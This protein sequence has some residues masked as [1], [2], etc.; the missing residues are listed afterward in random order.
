MATATSLSEQ[1]LNLKED[2]GWSWSEMANQVEGALNVKGPSGS[3][4]F[5]YAK[6]QANPSDLVEQTV[7]KAIQS[8]RE[9]QLADAEA[10]GTA[11]A[12][13]SAEESTHVSE[14]EVS[15]LAAAEP[16]EAV[17]TTDR[18]DIAKIT[19][20][21]EELVEAPVD[22]VEDDVVAE[23]PEHLTIRWA[24]MS[25]ATPFGAGIAPVLDEVI[26]EIEEAQIVYPT[27]SEQA[28]HGAGIPIDEILNSDVD[29]EIESLAPQSIEWAVLETEI[30]FAYGIS[31][32][33]VVT[34]VQTA[35][36]AAPAEDVVVT[37]EVAEVDVA[38][39]D[40]ELET[41][42]SFDIDEDTLIE[43]YEML[44]VEEAQTA[45]E[46]DVDPAEAYEATEE[47]SAEVVE[48]AE[49]AEQAEVAALEEE[50]VQEDVADSETTT[51]DELVD[52]SRALYDAPE[53][54]YD[55]FPTT[56]HIF[57][58]QLVGAEIPTMAELGVHEPVTSNESIDEVVI[59]ELAQFGEGSLY[60][61]GHSEFDHENCPKTPEFTARS[62][63]IIYSA[64][65]GE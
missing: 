15:E 36:V 10:N 28:A 2:M 58:E 62:R 30:A 33:P 61:N 16:E 46:H 29:T 53:Q 40:E 14:R 39:L 57:D 11:T 1:L 23:V 20:A 22:E 27:L 35:E 48:A 54:I 63:E 47:A 52:I 5:R 31:L 43:H 34:E 8:I 9:V 6:G 12:E 41:E 17:E 24:E 56:Y 32:T 64:P 51:L 50:S 49:V 60:A 13:S 55:F 4:L 42:S 19:E 3:T 25:E 38:E 18:A 65:M 26:E 44:A 7:L 21:V 45:F 59:L 37:E